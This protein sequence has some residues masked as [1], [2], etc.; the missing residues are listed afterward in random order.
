MNVVIRALTAVGAVAALSF[1]ITPIDAHAATPSASNP[2]GIASAEDVAVPTAATGR[3]VRNYSGKKY[4]HGE[5]PYQGW[6]RYH[7]NDDDSYYG[8]DGYGYY[9]YDDEYPLICREERYSCRAPRRPMVSPV[10]V[11]AAFRR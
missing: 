1:T 2:L 9:D 6:S 10:D 11:P 5:R 4:C 8:D 3:C 7:D